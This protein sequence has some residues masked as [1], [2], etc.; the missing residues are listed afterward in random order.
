[1]LRT[2]DVHADTT[3]TARS[4]H[5]LYSDAPTAR[6]RLSRL[7][8]LPTAG[9]LTGPHLRAGFLPLGHHPF[10]TRTASDSIDNYG[11]TND[12][13][14]A[15]KRAHSLSKPVMAYTL[16]QAMEQ[17][18]CPS[19]I[20]LP[21]VPASTPILMDEGDMYD[22]PAAKA[23]SATLLAHS[24]P[25]SPSRTMPM[26]SRPS[27]PAANFGMQRFL[28]TVTGTSK[29]A[30][31]AVTA[32]LHPENP[33]DLVEFFAHGKGQPRLKGIS[34]KLLLRQVRHAGSSLSGA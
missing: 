19:V 25:G 9:P 21:A 15:L 31:T 12:N 24:A 8:A 4:S 20:H 2:V 22:E 11:M 16:S 17:S 29:A 10:S 27:S 5:T 18:Y 28:A 3:C 13:L 32:P 34:R 7:V 14:R 1:M 23:P 33:A 26:A 30:A 6:S